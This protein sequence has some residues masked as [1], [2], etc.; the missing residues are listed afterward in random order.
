MWEIISYL[1]IVLV[2]ITSC[3][4]EFIKSENK[5]FRKASV[6]ICLLGIAGVVIN[7]YIQKN[8][9]ISESFQSAKDKREKANLSDMIKNITNQN[10]KLKSE[11]ITSLYT[12]NSLSD[13]INKKDKKRKLEFLNNLLSEIEVNISGLKIQLLEP[14]MKNMY[15]NP[16]DNRITVFRFKCDAMKSNIAES[17]INRTNLQKDIITLKSDFELGNRMLDNIC[18]QNDVT[19]RLDDFKTFYGNYGEKQLE[20]IN[21]VC[22]SLKDYIKTIEIEK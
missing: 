15:L 17:T 20:E 19:K 12:I 13:T 22:L 7:I 2:L 8:K 16:N 14:N 6:F 3:F 5:V 1:I 4:R 21:N 10:D 9:Q 18:T 11:L